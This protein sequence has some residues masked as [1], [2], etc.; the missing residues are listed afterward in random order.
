MPIAPYQAIRWWLWFIASV[1][2]RS[3]GLMPSR[4]SA[5]AIR[6]A[7]WATSAQLVR[8]V[9]PSAQAETISPSP[10]S[11]SAWSTSRITRSGQVLHRPKF[12]HASLPK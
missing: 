1:A 7:S 3:P 4:S 10:C 9:V 8:V 11:R 5:C 6:R 2:T 12:Q